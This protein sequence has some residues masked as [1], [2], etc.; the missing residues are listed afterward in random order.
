MIAN[1]HGGPVVLQLLVLGATQKMTGAFVLA[2]SR[3]TLA[4]AGRRLLHRWSWPSNGFRWR[5][6]PLG[7]SSPPF[8]DVIASPA[9]QPLPADVFARRFTPWTDMYLT[10]VCAVFEHVKAS[11][12]S[13]RLSHLLTKHERN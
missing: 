1:S 3:A 12:L 13:S 5:G 9:C 4:A 8:R 2:A 10:H 7:V 11:T 6:K